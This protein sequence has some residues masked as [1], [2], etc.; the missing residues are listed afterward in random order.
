MGIDNHISRTIIKVPTYNI[1]KN[2]IQVRDDKVD[3]EG[4]GTA[5]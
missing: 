1:K 4:T 5:K 3:N 2:I